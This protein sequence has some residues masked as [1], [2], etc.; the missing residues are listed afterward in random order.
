[1]YLLHSQDH[2]IFSDVCKPNVLFW[3]MYM[4]T[5]TGTPLPLP[6]LQHSWLY[7]RFSQQYNKPAHPQNKVNSE[8]TNT[9]W[10]YNYLKRVDLFNK[11]HITVWSLQISVIEWCSKT[12]RWKEDIALMY[13]IYVWEPFINIHV[14]NSRTVHQKIVLWFLKYP[15][16]IQEITSK[17]WYTSCQIILIWIV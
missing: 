10:I 1:M 16:L 15:T 8:D 12:P 4:H 17:I 11:D 3:Y 13:H 9:N 2:P 14:I 5:Q 6:T 7:F